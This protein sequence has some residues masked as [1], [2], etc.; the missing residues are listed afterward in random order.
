MA[1]DQYKTATQV[2]HH[3]SLRTLSG[4]LDPISK[5]DSQHTNLSTAMT[6]E[7]FTTHISHCH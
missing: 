3:A 1:V 7:T 2:Q 6:N 5:Y 4:F